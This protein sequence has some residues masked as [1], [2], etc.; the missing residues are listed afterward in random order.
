MGH[1]YQIACIQGNFWTP[2]GYPDKINYLN[3]FID[4]QKN[5]KAALG[6]QP[7][8]EFHCWRFLLHLMLTIHVSP[9]TT[10]PW[11]QGT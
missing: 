6:L 9:D 3:N 11:L 4:L 1:F 5:S 2:V 7:P 10:E 8:M